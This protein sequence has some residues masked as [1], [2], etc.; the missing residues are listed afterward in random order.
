[1]SPS[2]Y[3]I[4]NIISNKIGLHNI[5]KVSVNLIKK[6]FNLNIKYNYATC[7]EKY[8]YITSI[9]TIILCNEMY[10]KKETVDLL[11]TYTNQHILSED[12]IFLK[13]CCNYADIYINKTKKHTKPDDEL[14]VA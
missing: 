5:T 9:N 4:K 14:D 7:I 2:Q 3:L 11:Y 1:M 8:K 13:Q 10:T 6:K 12:I